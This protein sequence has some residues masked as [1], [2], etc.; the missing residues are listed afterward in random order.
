M[1]HNLAIINGNVAMAYQ[2][3]TPW[4][5]LGTRLGATADVVEAMR[6]ASLDWTVS[7]E[8]LQTPDGRKV[9]RNAVIR[10]TPDRP[11]LGTV[12]RDWTPVQNADAFAPLQDM[13]AN[14]GVTIAAAGA[15]SNG[16]RTWMLA[17]MPT[18]ISPIAGD[19]V[20]GFFLISNGHDGSLA[21]TA[22][23]TPIRVV[24]Q[25]T[26]TAATDGK[27]AMV[28]LR[29]TSNV[30]S[31]LAE[32]RRLIGTMLD[33][34]KATGDTFASMART[35]MDAKMVADY[36]AKVFP[37]PIDDAHNVTV[38]SRRDTVAALVYHGVGAELA[39]SNPRTGDT[40]AWAAYNAVTEYFD[41]V[42]PAE[43]GTA[44]AKTAANVSATFG[45]NL[46]LK[47]AALAAARQLVTV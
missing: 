14:H 40:T 5:S 11:I 21:Y 17:Q 32:S 22:R 9:D 12:G 16:G 44:K 38:A 33:A 18:D 3:T 31:R 34:M 35:D 1:A 7:L 15:L 46:T 45:A 19:V 25:N 23:L 36:I 24:C 42:R 29:H 4:H 10:D 2:G 47:I 20:K 43:A 39:G 37:M 30:E 6:V 27:K 41:H 13:C 8:Q 26:L 28:T